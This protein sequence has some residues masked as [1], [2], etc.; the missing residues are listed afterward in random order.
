MHGGGDFLTQEHQWVDPHQGVETKWKEVKAFIIEKG[1]LKKGVFVFSVLEAYYF[2]DVPLLCH[3]L[4]VT[5]SG[6]FPS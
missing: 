4:A 2:C 6:C 3:P 5:W 1:L